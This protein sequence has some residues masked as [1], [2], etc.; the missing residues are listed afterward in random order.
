[1]AKPT[2][3]I[4]LLDPSDLDGAFTDPKLNLMHYAGWT[5]TGMFPSEVGGK[6]RLALVLAPPV[7]AR[8][9]APLVVSRALWAWVAIQ[10]AFAVLA[11]F[12]VG[13]GTIALSIIYIMS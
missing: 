7:A 9:R 3:Q 8:E 5:I 4:V 2:F 1:M 12:C 6:E 10:V 11:L 13:W